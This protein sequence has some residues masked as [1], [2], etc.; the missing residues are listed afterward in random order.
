M[1]LVLFGDEGWIWV[2]VSFGCGWFVVVSCWSCWWY[3]GGWWVCCLSWCCSCLGGIGNVLRVVWVDFWIVIV[4]Y[5]SGVIGLVEIFV[6]RVLVS[7]LKEDN[8]KGI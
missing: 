3:V 2:C 6:L 4:R 5:V 8:E 7:N 1:D